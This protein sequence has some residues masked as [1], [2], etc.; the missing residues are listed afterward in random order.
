MQSKKTI[1]LFAYSYFRRN[2][3]SVGYPSLITAGSLYTT[4]ESYPAGRIRCK[5]LYNTDYAVKL[6]LH[7]AY[8]VLP[9]TH[10]YMLSPLDGVLHHYRATRMSAML[11]VDTPPLYSYVRDDFMTRYS[12]RLNASVV[13][14]LRAAGEFT[15]S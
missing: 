14:R 4:A 10:E 12:S 6:D 5:S 15:P 8:A 13:E 7:F 3:T 1:Q 2:K 9:G 11:D